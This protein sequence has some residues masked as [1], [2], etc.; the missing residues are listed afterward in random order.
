MIYYIHLG[1]ITINRIMNMPTTQKSI[2]GPS[3]S[4]LL[5]QLAEII[6]QVSTIYITFLTQ[7]WCVYS[8][9]SFLGIPLH[10]SQFHRP[11]TQGMAISLKPFL[12]GD[13]SH[14]LYGFCYPVSPESSVLMSWRE[15]VNSGKECEIR[16]DLEQ[17]RPGDDSISAS[18]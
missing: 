17:K 18:A 1:N 3:P 15:F 14:A 7:G 8:P 4:P 9:V 6:L 13:W 10:R 2:S 5:I 16:R 11:H 12:N